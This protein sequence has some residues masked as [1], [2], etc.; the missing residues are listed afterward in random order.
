MK[1]SINK[2]YWVQ[3]LTIYNVIS[4][5]I[6]EFW[7][8]FDTTNLT[9]LLATNKHF[10]VMIQNTIRWFHTNFSPLCD[11]CHDYKE[12]SKNLAE[13]G[14]DG[15][16]SYDTLWTWPWKTS[17]VAGGWIHQSKPIG[18]PYSCGSEGPRE[19]QQFQSHEKNPVL[20]P[21]LQAHFWQTS[22]QQVCDD[23]TRKFQEL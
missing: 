2:Y 6:K 21:P 10:S 3:E 17:A 19:C 12:K 15:I 16:Q 22:D 8:S 18:K 14:V 11:P 7:E 5:V 4:T 23:Q 13:T 1:P 20:W 9:N